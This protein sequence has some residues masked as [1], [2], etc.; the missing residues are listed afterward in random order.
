LVKRKR[1]KKK[2]KSFPLIWTGIVILLIVT[3][4]LVYLFYRESGRETVK[5]ILPGKKKIKR[6]RTVDGFDKRIRHSTDKHKIA[7]VIDDIGYD[8]WSA[9]ELLGMDV[10]ITLSILPHCP[11]STEV[12]ERAHRAG[13]EFILHLPMEPSDYPEKNPGEGALLTCMSN[14]ELRHRLEENLKSVP[15]VSG[16]NNHMGSRFMADEKK[17]EVVMKKLKEKNLFFVDSYTT[18]NTKGQKIAKKIGLK[19]AGR[20]VFIDNNSDFTDTL[21]TLEKAI[22]RRDHWQTLIIIGH[23]YKSTILAIKEAIPQFKAKGIEIVPLSDL[24]E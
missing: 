13:R 1:K 6:Q 10:P 23:P 2:K 5:E 14:N 20:D 16:V 15:H 24:T 12:A 17:L 7:I 22:D 11:Y 9:N 8:L 19:F 4:S 18:R 21:G 3:V